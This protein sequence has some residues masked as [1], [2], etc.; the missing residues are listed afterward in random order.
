MSEPLL[1][2][3]FMYNYVRYF[4]A[5]KQAE[6]KNF[7]QHYLQ[8]YKAKTIADFCCGTSDFA[9]VCPKD[10]YYVGFD[11][12]IHFINFSKKRYANDKK[13]KFIKADVIKSNQIYKTKFGCVLL[14]SAVHHFSDEEPAML[15][16]KIKKIFKK[17]Q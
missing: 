14:I 8:K 3:P 12:N 17:P 6:M 2:N 15:L 1:D 10:T 9:M 13:K 4:L 5:G 11:N 7:I 16:P